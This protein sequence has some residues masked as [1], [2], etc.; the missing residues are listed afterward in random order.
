MSAA[1][2]PAEP[3]SEAADSAAKPQ[4]EPPAPE[5]KTTT[6]A[7]SAASASN[8]ASTNTPEHDRELLKVA[9][10]KIQSR[11]QQDLEKILT[12]FEKKE[13][14]TNDDVEKGL[15]C[16][17]SSAFRYL[18]ELVRQGKIKRLGQTGAGVVYI[19]A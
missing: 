10:A 18:R 16:S 2:E 13:K 7:A 17:D 6:V 14:I 3:V 9:R 4:S 15:K 12:L 1:S 8:A 5:S 11:K 19:K